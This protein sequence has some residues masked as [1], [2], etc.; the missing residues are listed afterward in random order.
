MKNL[1]YNCFKEKPGESGPCPYCGFD[2][3]DNAKKYPVALRAGTILNNRYIV[4]RVL[5][6]GGF[7]ITYLAWDEKLEARVAV[8]EYMPNDISARVG[9][10]VS[11]AMESRAEDF[12]YGE[13]RFQEEARIL[14]KFMG[15]PNIAGVTDYFDENGTSYFVMDYI[16]G[17]SFKTYIANQGG[18]VSPEEALDVMIPVLRALTAVHAEGFIHRDV[19]PDNI[20]I[21]KDGNVKLLDFGSARY[22]IGDKS[23]SLDVILKVGYA[24]KEQYIRRGRQGPYTD[25]YSCAAC[26]YAAITGYLPPESLERLDHDNLVPPSQ[27]GVEIPLYL[28]R[29][30]L[31]GLAVQPEDRFQT[32]GEFLDALESQEVVELPPGQGGGKNLAGAE[33]GNGSAADG[34]LRGRA[35][36]G[37]RTGIMHRLPLIIGGIAAAAVILG[38]GTLIGRG[39]SDGNAGSPVAEALAAKVTIA[40]EEY[41]TALTELDLSGKNL[42]DADIIS[43]GEIKGLKKLILENNSSISDISP[44]ANL[45]ELEELVLPSPSGIT[46]LSPVAGLANLTRLSITGEWNNMPPASNI[47]DFSPISRLTGLTRLDLVLNNAFDLSL[48][49]GLKELTILRLMGSVTVE[50]LSSISGLTKIKQL[51][52]DGTGLTDIS[53]IAGMTE[54]Y[55]LDIRGS[56]YMDD[57][58]VLSGMTKLEKLRIDANGLRS[59]HGMENLVKLREADFYGDNATY[60]DVDP[61]KNLT[62][63]EILRL[64]SHGQNMAYSIDGLSGLINLTDLQMDCGARSLEPLRNLI[65]LR[66]LSAVNGGMVNGAADSLEPLSGLTNLQSL[67]VRIRPANDRVDLSPLANLTQLKTLCVATDQNDHVSAWNLSA[68]SGLTNLSS[69]ELR[70]NNLADLSALASLSNLQTLTISDPDGISDW[71]PVSHVSVVNKGNY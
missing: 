61:L 19:T 23:K 2:L 59:F 7:G 64:P 14:A 34:N 16:E 12:T 22:S 51:R 5:G 24:P 9:T 55:D 10:T 67:S 3:E 38:V 4:G 40:G 42:T 37:K 62:S 47:Q 6:Q 41:S 53:G 21:T 25:V 39:R 36:S 50:D 68:L 33:E 56:F 52:I 30:I 63:L 17:I 18:K 26:L 48:L 69:L 49:S 28:E 54:M 45:T 1:C 8:K 46:D 29:A 27:A 65:N 60:T 20:Y 35:N 44:L 66:S 71:S 70:I 43:L 15:Q 13:E 31:K 57:L 11:V 32:A 58:S